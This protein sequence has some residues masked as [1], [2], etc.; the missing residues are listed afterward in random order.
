[1]SEQFAAQFMAKSLPSA[2]NDLAEYQQLG[3]L[4]QIDISLATFIGEQANVDP[5][6][7]LLVAL[8]SHQA[9]RGHICLDLAGLVKDA[10]TTLGVPPMGR[11]HQVTTTPNQW[12][13]GETVTSLEQLLL[14][15]G[16]VD[17]AAVE[18][19]NAPLV[20]HNGL[21]YLRRFFEDEHQVAQQLAVR[22]Q[23][24][25]ELPDDLSARLAT[26]FDPLKDRDE[27]SGATVHWQSVAAAIAARSGLTVISGGP[28]TGKTTTVVRLLAL[29]QGLSQQSGSTKTPLRIRLAAPTGKAAARL[30]ESLAGT[31]DR[32]RSGEVNEIPVEVA[33]LIPAEVATIHRLLGARPNSRFFK[34]NR[35]NP[36]HLDVLVVDE[37]SMVDLG[38]M[39]SL[40]DAVPPS[41]RLILLGDKDQLAS[42]EAGAVLGDLCRFAEQGRY[43]ADTQ[44]Y[45]FRTSGYD[46]EPWHGPGTEI[47][48]QI[49]MLRKSHRFGA[50]SG[51]GRLAAAVNAGDVDQARKEI[52]AKSGDLGYIGIE[53]E[54]F[55]RL[56]VDGTVAQLQSQGG[57]NPQGYRH[58][59]ALLKQ[60]P[61][62]GHESDWQRSVLNAFAEF[63]LLAA[64][65]EGE[66]GVLGLN[67]RV[68]SLLLQQ[69]LIDA[70]SGWYAGRPVMVMRNDY[71]LNL[72]NGDV[73]ICMPDSDGQLR[74]IFPM[75]DGSLKA[76]LPSRLSHVETVY[77]MTVH[78]SQ[79]SEFSH[80]ALVMPDK[81]N[82]VLTKELIYTGITRAKRWFT[83]VST[84][85]ALLREAINTKT[86]RASG[87]AKR[88]GLTVR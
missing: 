45:V 50:N 19:G 48:Q 43:Q 80:T 33:E 32:I 44:G 52:T 25:F 4:R 1:M 73:G 81:P 15:S 74:V 67:Q 36:L 38:M 87:L 86:E 68:A 56:V 77:A 66:W 2:L 26:L 23:Q 88:L 29:L 40:L 13:V 65:R 34:H 11:E 27:R 31:L 22:A 51:I 63:Q 71:T 69:G 57:S 37:A 84:N 58:Y 39:A 21:L 17:D 28:G 62:Q 49:V 70:D 83:L 78:K 60:G 20:L 82:P 41:A 54:S 9:G 16:V 55:K 79:G 12:L 14:A 3:W 35:T 8:T 72:M 64:V 6:V 42:V 85:P 76:V 53:S 47:E 18:S 24:R 61:Q 30:S 10:V 59:L 75:A 5:R 7:L 46:L